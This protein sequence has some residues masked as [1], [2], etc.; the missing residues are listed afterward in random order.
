MSSN[1]PAEVII[2]PIAEQVAALQTALLDLNNAHAGHTSLLT[3]AAWRRLVGSAFE[4]IS[5]DPPASLIITLDQDA[6]YDSPNFKWFRDRFSHFVYI[7][8]IVVADSH[9]GRGLASSLYRELQRRALFAGHDRLVCEVNVVPPNLT[10]D[11]FHASMGFD[12]VGRA[13]LNDGAKT[14]R[15]L[16]KHVA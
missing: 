9:R 13:E 15:Y 14:V 11:A 2:Q 6:E 4:A 12:E 8:R 3:P 16:V 5:I 7:D 1:Q 10:S